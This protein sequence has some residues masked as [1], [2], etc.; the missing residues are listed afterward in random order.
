MI[1]L[2]FI[3]Q[4]KIKMKNMSI[5]FILLL[6]YCTNLFSL[7]VPDL[8]KVF[9]GKTDTLQKN[10]LSK[11]HYQPVDGGYQIVGSNNIFNRVL[12]GGHEYDY[13]P[14]KY[15]TIASDRLIVL[16][17]ITDWRKSPACLHAKCGTFMVGTAY[18]PGVI[19]PKHSGNVGD[20]YSE[21]FHDSEGTVATYKNGWMEYEISTYYQCFPRVTAKIEVLPINTENGFLVHLKV[22]TDQ[23]VNFVMGFGGITDFIGSLMFPY[24]TARNFSSSDC[25]GNAV[26]IEDKTGIVSGFMG[27]SVKTTMQIGASFP[28]KIDIGDAKKI[29][30]PSLFIK[31]DSTNID[32]PMVRM[33]CE[34]KQGETLDGYV[35]VIRNASKSALG[36]YLNHPNPVEYLK[37][38]IRKTRSAIE[39]STPDNMLD[40]TVHPSVLAVDASW[41]DKSFYHGGYDWHAPYLGWR[42]WYGPTVIGW[43]DRVKESFKTF[44]NLQVAKTDKTEEVVYNGG[45][46]SIL[47]NS[48]GYLPDMSDGRKTIFYNMQE[49]G[50]DMILH[51]MEW[52]GDLSYAEEVFNCISGVLDWEKRILDPDNDNLYQNWL[53][54]WVSDAHSYNGGGCAQS[55]AYNY[56]ANKVM[57]NLASRL[58]RNSKLFLDRSKNIR[59]AVQKT[60]WIPEKGIMAEYIDVIGN[61]LLHPSPELATIYHSIEAEIV[62]PF[63]AYQMLLFTEDVLRN[64]KTKAR[65]GRLVWSSNWYPQI[66]SSCGLYTAEN[67]HLAWAY[68]KC[69]QIQKGNE[70]LKGIVDAHFLSRY[71][72]AVAHCMTPDGYSDG[73]FD[74]TDVSSMY[75]RLIVEGLFGLRFNLLDGEILVAPSFPSDWNSASLKVPD[76]ALKYERKDQT[77]IFRFQCDIKAERIFS[78]PLHSTEIADVYINKNSAEYFIEPGIGSSKLIVKSN[79]VGLI[80]LQVSYI[81]NPIP[82]LVFPRYVSAG[83]RVAFQVDRG[84]ITEI[85][86]PSV[87]LHG[88]S[89]NKLSVNA[90][91]GGI[92]GN[93][94]VFIRVKDRKWDGWLAA[95]MII[96]KKTNEVKTT[97][98]SGKSF[99]PV[100]ISDNFNISLSEIHKLEYWNPRPKGYSFMADFNGRFGWDWNH[101]G[102]Q[103]IVIDDNVLRSSGGEYFTEN[104]IPFSTPEKGSNAACVSIWKNFPEELSFRLSGR[105]AELAVFF[106]GVTNPMQSRVENARFTV[107]YSDGTEERVALVNPDNFDDWLVAAVQ[108]ENE[109]QYFSDYNHGIIQRISLNPSRDLKALKVRAIANEVIVGILGISIRKK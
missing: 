61:K 60:L 66:Y 45:A 83:E 99:I 53:N 108:Q 2:I 36:K 41:H 79:Q 58:G 27:N 56:R 24:F 59:N 85:K 50:V 43:H 80:E 44:A 87:C 89:Q 18:T 42:T 57:A 82:K 94:T 100:D 104:G 3:I 52:T 88:I 39:I 70:I 9:N 15:F 97:T 21:W 34:I 6:F 16:G 96:V 12:Y 20:R 26:A 101:A 5:A 72:G 30:Y 103:K 1:I 107:E 13:L 77:E 75:L 76:A 102:Y 84:L 106:I 17:A 78:I 95:D 25:I 49:V 38:E 4:K 64:E 86:D 81:S 63:Q 19:A 73:S 109:T 62:D 91:I 7:Q 31:N 35:V 32:A 23:R 40:L 8:N 46:C 55:S 29:E 28:V 105:G 69:G 14:E 54:T 51:D 33:Q 93:H 48:Y 11:L 67:I 90:E 22:Q 68:F 10:G 37:N 92:P 47:K 74:F 65:G 98:G 71:P